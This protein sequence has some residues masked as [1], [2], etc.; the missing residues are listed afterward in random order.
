MMVDEYMYNNKFRKNR[1]D[2]EPIAEMIK[3]L[4]DLE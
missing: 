1:V 4:R 2:L 3:E